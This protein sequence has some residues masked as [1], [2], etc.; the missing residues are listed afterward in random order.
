MEERDL[1]QF[2]SSPGGE[3]TQVKKKQGAYFLPSNLYAACNIDISLL[4]I[5]L[6][7]P[8]IYPPADWTSA[9]PPDQR[10][11]TLS[12]LSG[13][14][15]S[16]PTVEIVDRYRPVTLIIFILILEIITRNCVV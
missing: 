11:R 1:I 5:K 13:G 2:S 10:P 14:Y 8:M 3:S 12:D 15:L 7:Q 9:C 16:R 4:P 6:N